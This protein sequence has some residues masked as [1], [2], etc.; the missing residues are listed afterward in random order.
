[1]NI[2][3]SDLYRL[4]RSKA[5]KVVCVLMLA[6]FV[7]MAVSTLHTANQST[8]ELLRHANDRMGIEVPAAARGMAGVMDAVGSTAVRQT[9]IREMSFERMLKLPFRGNLMYM[10]AVI[11][12]TMFAGK[13]IRTGY[14]K[15]LLPARGYRLGWYAGKLLAAVCVFAC[16]LV[17]VFVGDMLATLMLGN[18]F[19]GDFFVYAPLFVHAFFVTM[20]LCALS[21]LLLVLFHNRTLALVLAFAFAANLQMPFLYLIDM[22]PWFPFKLS[23]YNIMQHAASLNVV[24]DPGVLAALYPIGWVMLAVALVGS[25]AVHMRR[26]FK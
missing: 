16:L 25:Y 22:T 17:S 19:P 6:L 14:V 1:M 3:K 2:V 5:L 11:A 10:L 8:A 15:N 26:D 9:I 12:F 18:P 24:T 21:L 4:F 7:I 13:D 20:V 23:D